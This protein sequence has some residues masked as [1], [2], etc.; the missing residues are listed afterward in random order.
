MIDSA[1]LRRLLSPL[2]MIYGLVVRARLALYRAG[3][4]ASRG[5]PGRVIS[6]GN[7]TVGGTGKT[8][9]VAFIAN[10]LRGQGSEVAILSRGYR[11]QSRGRLEVSDGV[12]M[13]HGPAASGDEPWLLAQSCPGVR[14]VVDAR[15]Y[16][17]GKWL[18]ERTPVSVFLLDDGYQHL[19]LARQLNLLLIDATDPLDQARLVPLGRLREP[20][21]EMRRA[22]AVIVTRGDQPF[23]R[24][25]L[26]VL[27]H[28][29]LRPGTPVFLAW[30][31]LTSFRRLAA[32]EQ[33]DAIHFRGR[34]VAAIAGLAR[35]ERFF[36]DLRG[37][38]IEMAWNQA[39]PDHHRYTVGEIREICD[40]AQAAGAQA[41]LIT[42][43][44]AAN[45]PPEAI[46]LAPLP[47]YAASIEFRCR[48]E[49]EFKRLLRGE[50]AR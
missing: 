3:I 12:R 1:W 5:L 26:E 11:R 50:M 33:V 43:K 29:Y 13:R 18:A 36:H 19:R 35:P 45:L 46:A 49:D 42:E 9:C 23:D 32:E 31:E 48:E 28:R 6:V 4:L 25:R 34:R 21:V 38:G 44:D 41:L 7:L 27:L 40:A 16:E 10:Y 8:P 47:I 20:L 14:V 39:F 24:S 2:A 17:A 22:D 30:H 37:L 15:R